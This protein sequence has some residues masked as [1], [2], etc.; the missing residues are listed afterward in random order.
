MSKDYESL[1][2][3]KKSLKD[4]HYD[5]SVPS[6]DAVYIGRIT[7]LDF[8]SIK[9]KLNPYQ[10]SE[11]GIKL[12]EDDFKNGK[13]IPSQLNPDSVGAMKLDHIRHGYNKHNS[14]YTQ[15][16]DNRDDLPDDFDSIKNLC[17]LKDATIACF[18]QDPGNTNPWH[19]DTYQGVVNEYKKQGIE[20]L[21]SEIKN[22]KRYLIVLED[23]DW[24]H[25]LQ[26]GNNVLSQWKA[27]DIFTWDYG[28]YHTTGN[29]GLKPKLTAHITGLPLENALHLRGEYRFNV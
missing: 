8:S 18:K 12:Y 4:W 22:I 1:L 19:F 21:D 20:L 7:N 24:G 25:F 11:N 16:I 27:G 9:L 14:R 23:W 6:N 29:A 15:W 10:A 26:I 5:P 2:D 13:L 3:Y 28:I 17:S